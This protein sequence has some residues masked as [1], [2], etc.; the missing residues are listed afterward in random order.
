MDVSREGAVLA[1]CDKLDLL[2]GCFSAGLVPKGSADPLGLRRAAHGVCLILGGELLSGDGVSL[3]ASIRKS[4][5][6]YE[7]QGRI[8]AEVDEVC[9]SVIA[10]IGQRLRHLMESDGISFDT[11][12]AITAAGFDNLGG[13]WKRGR[14]LSAI[15]A[16]EGEGDFE[17]LA[18]SAKRI[19]NI[20]SQARSKGEGEADSPVDESR[21]IDE[22]EKEL[23]TDLKRVRAQVEQHWGAGRYDAIWA[24][25]ASLRPRVDG[26]FDHVMV[27]DKDAGLRKNRL[28]KSFAVPIVKKRVTFG[29]PWTPNS[30]TSP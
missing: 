29:L 14:T 3:E 9:G 19:R 13:A 16:T 11:A 4:H 12:R 1:V 22:R 26:F 27:M 7:K 21:L 8:T 15:R 5:E 24:A 2:V 18:S 17:A 6:T 23:Y 25:I 10:F 28:A 30:V 20:L